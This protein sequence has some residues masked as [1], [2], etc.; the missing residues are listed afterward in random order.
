MVIAR[1]QVLAGLLVMLVV[2]CSRPSPSTSSTPSASQSQVVYQTDVPRTWRADETRE[3]VVH[4]VNQGATAWNASGPNP[5]QLGVYFTQ[6]ASNSLELALTEQHFPLTADV[7]QGQSTDVRVRVRA[8]PGPGAFTLVHRLVREQMG[9]FEELQ[10]LDVKVSAPERAAAYFSSAAAGLKGSGPEVIPVTL[11]N[12]GTLTWQV[13]SETP[14][15]LAVRGLQYLSRRL[16][17]PSPHARRALRAWKG[18]R[19]FLTRGLVPFWKA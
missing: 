14:V 4:L 6:P 7:A 2:A 15:Q 3:Y 13:R 1:G 18:A 19:H 16:H 11:T 8:P 12:L 9:W 10:Q 5:V 17:G